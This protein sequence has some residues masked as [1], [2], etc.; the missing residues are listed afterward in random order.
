MIHAN[1][2]F[3]PREAPPFIAY[4]PLKEFTAIEDH[5]NNVMVYYVLRGVLPVGGAPKEWQYHEFCKV[6]KGGATHGKQENTDAR[7]SGQGC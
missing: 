4:A 5:R 1:F 6:F 7:G 2:K 3:V